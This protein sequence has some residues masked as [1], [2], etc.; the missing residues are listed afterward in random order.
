M[1]AVVVALAV[2]IDKLT[3]VNLSAELLTS[4]KAKGRMLYY[5]PL[6]PEDAAQAQAQAA[7]GDG[8]GWIGWH[9]DSG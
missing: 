2:H 7:G 3:G 5:Y 8:D 6:T 4:H 9:N 1:H